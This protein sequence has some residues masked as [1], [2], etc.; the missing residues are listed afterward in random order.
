MDIITWLVNQLCI[1]DVRQVRRCVVNEVRG[2]LGTFYCSVG[3]VVEA[4]VVTG[5]GGIIHTG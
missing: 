3:T 5:Q 2:P 1:A 4:V